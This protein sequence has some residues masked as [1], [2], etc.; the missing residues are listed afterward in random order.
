MAVISAVADDVEGLT[1]DDKLIRSKQFVEKGYPMDYEKRNRHLIAELQRVQGALSHLATRDADAVRRHPVSPDDTGSLFGPNVL[2]QDRWIIPF[3]SPWERDLIVLD[4][5]KLARRQGN[6]SQ[7]ITLS[8]NS[9]IRTRQDHCISS[10]A[11][12]IRPARI[13]GLNVPLMNTGM[14]YHD[15]GHVPGGHTGEEFLS[16]RKG[17]DGR[18]HPK[19][20]H[21][22]MGVILAQKIERGG[23]GLGLTWQVLDIF[24][25]HSS[26]VG[27]ALVDRSMSEETALS[28]KSDKIDYTFA[29]IN[30]ILKR[31]PLASQGFTAKR[32]AHILEAA[33]WFGR[34]Q[35][36]RVFTCI[37]NLC[38]ESAE[39]GHV[40]FDEC[41]AAVK[42][43]ELKRMMYRDIYL[44]IDRRTLHLKMEIVYEMLEKA[45]VD[46]DPA[47]VFAMLDDI[48]LD[49]LAGMYD[50]HESI[51]ERT[52]NRISVGEV[53]KHLRG[54][55][56]DL[57]DP[58]LDW[59]VAP[60]AADPA[61]DPG[62]VVAG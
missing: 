60:K 6:K 38:I 15:G 34:N 61:P 48:E 46:V 1:R 55:T 54:K 37:V 18:G 57:T 4:E 5:S 29:D 44:A 53:L 59:G 62:P 2:D 40:S 49:L 14:R 3:V 42:F 27:R 7:V 43:E 41:E 9:H 56:I 28:V 10:A 16:E 24:H 21:N 52:L 31:E 50:R 17:W 30:D 20:K 39:K 22:V 35:R 19:F 13:L 51:T 45:L 23:R 33:D 32:F 36:E 58:D 12:A 8:P 26:G 11:V 47:L 25:R